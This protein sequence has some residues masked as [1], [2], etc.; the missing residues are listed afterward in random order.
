MKRVIEIT[1]TEFSV[2]TIN[3][4]Q[5]NGPLAWLLEL[6]VLFLV[7]V[8]LLAVALLIT[9]PIWLPILIISLII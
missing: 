8:I 3:G 4:K 9:M 6:L 2:L 1:R 7:G 5:Y